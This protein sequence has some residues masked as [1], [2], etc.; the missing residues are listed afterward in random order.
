MLVAEA[1]SSVKSIAL[2]TTSAAGID[3]ADS[4]FVFIIVG[5]YSRVFLREKHFCVF[6][7]QPSD[8]DREICNLQS[9][10]VLR[11]AVGHDGPYACRYGYPHR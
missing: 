9:M 7:G 11:S 8:D 6:V 4:K 1:E 5:V 3:V 2:R 10:F